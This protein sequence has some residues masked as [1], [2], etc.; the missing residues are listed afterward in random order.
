MSDISR[1][2]YDILQNEYKKLISQGVDHI[3]AIEFNGKDAFELEEFSSWT[4]AE[5]QKA[6]KELLAAGL[7][8]DDVLGSCHLPE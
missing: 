1:K 7:I 5:I 8:K 4:Q 6:K 3:N 2:A